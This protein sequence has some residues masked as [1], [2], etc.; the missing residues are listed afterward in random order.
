DGVRQIWSAELVQRCGLFSHSDLNRRARLA[1]DLVTGKVKGR[2]RLRLLTERIKGLR[3]IN[4]R[5]AGVGVVGE[6]AACGR[7]RIIEQKVAANDA[8][9]PDAGNL[10]QR[11]GGIG[12]HG[13][14]KSA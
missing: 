8:A 1:E 6:D 13:L 7:V 4:L 2:T 11:A 3:R 14:G 9:Q 5:S 12:G 10:R